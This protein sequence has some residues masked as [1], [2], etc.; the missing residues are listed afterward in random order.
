MTA[1]VQAQADQQAERMRKIVEEKRR[2]RLAEE[3]E[4]EKWLEPRGKEVGP[5]GKWEEP[6]NSPLVAQQCEATGTVGEGV[7]MEEANSAD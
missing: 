4:A 3:E 6:H 5:R 2:K 7:Y 1:C